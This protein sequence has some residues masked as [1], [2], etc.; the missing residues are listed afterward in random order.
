[1]RSVFHQQRQA[2]KHLEKLKINMETELKIYMDEKCVLNRDLD[3][4]LI[5]K[6]AVESSHTE[7]K[8]ELV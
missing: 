5:A 3:I 4:A 8:E 2:V 6:M 1:M 7:E